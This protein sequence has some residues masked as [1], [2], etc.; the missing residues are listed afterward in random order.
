MDNADCLKLRNIEAFP[1]EVE[2]KRV[3]CLRDPGN[4][5]KKMLFVSPDTFFAIS[6]FDGRH[7]LLDIQSE[8]ARRFGD[9]LYKEKIEEIVEE[10]DSHLF[11]QSERFETFI[12]NL[13]ENF[14]RSKTRQAV[15]AGQGYPDDPEELE[16][17]ISN[18]FLPSQGGP[19]QITSGKNDKTLKGVIAPHIDFNRG[20]PCYAWA[21]KEVGESCD[22]ELFIILGTV[23]SYTKNLFVLTGKDFETPFGILRTDSEFVELLKKNGG[24]RFFEDEFAHRAEHSLEFQSVF[25]KYL[26]RRKREVKIVPILCGSFHQMLADSIPPAEADQ[27]QNF[28]GALRE[29]IS[30]TDQKI[31]LIASADL[32]HIGPQFGDRFLVDNFIL[33]ETEEKDREMLGFLEK[34]DR[35]GFYHSIQRDND[36]R[37]ICGFPPIYTMLSVLNAGKGKIL[38]YLQWNDPAGSAAVTFASMSFY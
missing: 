18:Y 23:H 30:T 36:K 16:Q 11:L 5:S 9:L 25:L 3:I 31:C 2:G 34:L 14:F 24:A 37:K 4:I 10:L 35:E 15:F 19:G 28:I 29:A 1:V 38:K 13:R 7:S 12:R 17:Q 6:L 27:F 21:H 20:G 32:A 33:K 22:A 8:Y 26:F